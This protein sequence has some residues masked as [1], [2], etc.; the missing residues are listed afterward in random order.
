MQPLVTVIV[1]AYNAEKYI[2]VAIESVLAQ[3]FDDF[4]LLV[5]NDCSTDSTKAV[6]EDFV[7]RDKRV[8]L[9]GLPANMGA[10]AGPR[11]IGVRQA[12]GKWVA[13]LD[14]DDV[15]HPHKLERQLDLLKRTKAR[16]CSTQMI[17]FV[18]ENHLSLL[19][20]FPDD[21]EWISFR[22]QLIKF[23]TPTSSVMVEK[24]LIGRYPFNER[25]EF[26]AR[27]D[28]DCWL[29]CHEEIRRSVKITR[30]M[31]GYRIV[32]G[33]ISGSKW[34]MIKRHFYVLSQYRFLSGKSLRAGALLFTI[35]HFGLAIY[36]RLIKKTL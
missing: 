11:N 25:I 32:P 5:I 1:P 15:W 16:F 30:P 33:Q 10:P 20:A 26:K 14:A 13:F 2:S 29:H 8:R 6:V 36:Y 31:L 7:N 9:I 12:R 21:Y 22:S 4:E 34:A 3:S 28:L 23:R 18:D 27:E 24:E 35:S 17:D 19:D